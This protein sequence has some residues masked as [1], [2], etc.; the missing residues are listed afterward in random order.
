MKT[1][2]N[3][4][5]LAVGYEDGVVRLF[6]LNSGECLVTFSGHKTAVTCLN[7][8]EE[9]MRLVSGSKDTNIIVW[10]TVAEAG[11][12]RLSGHKGPITQCCF[13]TKQNL[14]ISSSEDTL[15]KFWDLDTQHCFKTLVG[16]R[17]QVWD[18]AVMRDD[19]YLVTGCGDSELRVWKIQYLDEVEEEEEDTQTAL[20]KRQR[21]GSESNENTEEA[22][23][24][25]SCTKMGTILRKATNR[26]ISMVTDSSKS[27]LACHGADSGIELFR[28]HDDEEIQKYFGKRQRKHK[29]QNPESTEEL[30]IALKDEFSRINPVKAS[31]KVKAIDLYLNPKGSMSFFFNDNNFVFLRFIEIVESLNHCMSFFLGLKCLRIPRKNCMNL[32]TKS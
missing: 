27:L 31:G 22:D 11:L 17:S 26:L 20:S 25:I 2:P 13:L 14:L 5:Q 24:I 32:V 29:K 8:D 3:N 21:N 23:T 28:F 7:F 10:D 16:H 30:T 9:G 19:R 12:Y 18:I 15:V 4:N 6:D 1:S